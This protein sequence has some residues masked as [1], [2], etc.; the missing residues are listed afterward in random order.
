M[1]PVE[2]NS[3]KHKTVAGATIDKAEFVSDLSHELRTILGGVIGI[4]ELLLA[5]ELSPHQRQLSQTVEQ[6]SKALLLMLNDIVDFTR[7]EL[8]KVSSESVPFDVKELISEILPQLD[9]LLKE[10]HGKVDIKFKTIPPLIVSDRNCIRQIMFFLLLHMIKASAGETVQILLTCAD[11]SDNRGDLRVS[12]SASIGEYDHLY[13]STL[14]EPLNSVRKYDSRWLALYLCHRLVAKMKGTCGA[15][16]NGR[17][18]QLWV[19]LPV[20]VPND[21]T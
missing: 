11:V 20:G 6:S 18:C 1:S 16:F 8:N 10:K 17:N 13:L 5:S 4:N 3:P 12:T 14:N 7:M 21:L 2:P 9:Y 15:E 19:T